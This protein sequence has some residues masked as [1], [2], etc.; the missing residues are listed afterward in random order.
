MMMM[1]HDDF[2]LFEIE[3]FH[4]ESSLYSI[5][6]TT[7]LVKFLSAPVFSLSAELDDLHRFCFAD[8]ID[9]NRSHENLKISVA[10]VRAIY[11]KS[12]KVR[13]RIGNSSLRNSGSLGNRK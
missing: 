6:C 7:S 5:F 3:E 10:V 4:S 2:N 12:H 1:R 9:R 13:R 11:L 8:C